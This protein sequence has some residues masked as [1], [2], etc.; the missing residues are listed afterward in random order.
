M[1]GTLTVSAVA[2][3]ATF[4]GLSINLLGMGYVLTASAGGLTGVDSSPLAVSVAPA[5]AIAPVGPV[6]TSIAQ[7]TSFSLNAG[8]LV[9]NWL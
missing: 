7:E 8:V 9:F 5:E 6:T 4:S 2:G 3:V 1:S